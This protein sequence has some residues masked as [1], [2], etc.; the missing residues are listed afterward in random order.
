MSDLPPVRYCL[1]TNVLIEAWNRYYSPKFCS[2]YWDILNKLG[3]LNQI[4]I[5]KAVSDEIKRSEDELTNWLK[6]S[7]IPVF[8]ADRKVSECLQRI[9][10]T[11]PVHKFLVDNKR[12]RSLADPWVIAHALNENACV[13]TK[14]EKITAAKENKIKIP[15]V[16]ENMG[17]RWI[18]D[19]QMIEELEIK[20][21]CSF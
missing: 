7:S 9:Y 13:V 16:C 8:E 4:F 6:Q 18:D 15:N 14:E 11:N 12:Y 1:D 21:S 17:I 19:F 2:S 5:P 20:F 3:T 10:S